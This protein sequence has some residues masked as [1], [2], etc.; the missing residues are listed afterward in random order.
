VTSLPPLAP[1]ALPADVRAGSAE[2]RSAYAAALGFERVLVGELTKSLQRT[3]GDDADRAGGPYGSLVPEALADAIAAGGGLGLAHDLYR[4][5]RPPA[6][7]A[8]PAGPAEGAA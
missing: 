1:G 5:A 7:P 4:D 2:D 3:A 8:A 6:A